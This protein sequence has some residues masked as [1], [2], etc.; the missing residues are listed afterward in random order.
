MMYFSIVIALQLVFKY[1]F[2][3]ISCKFRTEKDKEIMRILYEHFAGLQRT[4]ELKKQDIFTELCNMSV[5][6]KVFTLITVIYAQASH[7]NSERRGS[8]I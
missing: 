6:R 8:L 1:Y 3:L 5:I 7:R 2:T 4:V